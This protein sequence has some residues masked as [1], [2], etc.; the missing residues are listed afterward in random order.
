MK[1]LEN[2]LAPIRAQPHRFLP[3]KSIL[4][5]N[6]FL[7]GVKRVVSIEETDRDKIRFSRWL[8][9]KYG[10]S[11]S[12]DAISVLYL[13][14]TNEEDAF[15]RYFAEW[16][17]FTNE[18]GDQA[19]RWKLVP[20]GRDWQSSLWTLSDHV[21]EAFGIK[22]V[23]YL[24]SAVDGLSHAAEFCAL[25]GYGEG[26]EREFE[27]WLRTRR[28]WKMAYRWERSLLFMSGGNEAKAYGAFFLLAEQFLGELKEKTVRA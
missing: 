15:D 4:L 5:L 2:V 23:R 18:H 6:S 27:E 28:R 13:S 20:I 24:R 19:E 7:V 17:I 1:T 12:H 26:W 16:D 8:A 14:S 22:C 3:E 21:E 9:R 25:P 11:I 10:F